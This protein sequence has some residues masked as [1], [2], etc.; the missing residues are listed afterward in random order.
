MTFWKEQGVKPANE[1]G[2]ATPTLHGSINFANERFIRYASLH[3][4][5]R[6]PLG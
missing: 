1:K 4:V 5:R 2:V 6:S 3:P